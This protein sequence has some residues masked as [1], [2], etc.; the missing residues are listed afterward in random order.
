MYKE[1]YFSE[2]PDIGYCSNCRIEVPESDLLP[3]D[4][5]FLCDKCYD[6]INRK[7]EMLSFRKIESEGFY[8]YED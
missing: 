1:Q 8:D 2:D 5:L 3:Y 4:E 6:K 7:M